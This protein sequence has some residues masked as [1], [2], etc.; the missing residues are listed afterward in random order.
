MDRGRERDAPVTFGETPTPLSDADAI[1]KRY[2]AFPRCSAAT[3]VIL[4][5]MPWLSPSGPEVK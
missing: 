2:S 3:G 4:P 5:R 1:L